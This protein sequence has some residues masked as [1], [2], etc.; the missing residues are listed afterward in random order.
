MKKKDTT[1]KMKEKRKTSICREENEKIIFDAEINT[2]L[3]SERQN[4]EEKQEWK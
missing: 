1:K 2:K 3:D 4:G